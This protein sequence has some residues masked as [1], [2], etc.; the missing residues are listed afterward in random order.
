MQP[1]TRA[2]TSDDLAR[3]T[4][5][6][7]ALARALVR[8]ESR[9]EDLVQDTVVVALERPPRSH[10]TPGAWL[11]TVARRLAIDRLR[12]DRR[13]ARERGDRRRAGSGRGRRAGDRAAVREAPAVRATGAVPPT[14]SSTR[15]EVPTS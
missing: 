6:L 14:A 2:L 7:R 10:G 13:G 8:D 5:S 4:A 1:G 12:A 15:G 11:A 9:A 3:H